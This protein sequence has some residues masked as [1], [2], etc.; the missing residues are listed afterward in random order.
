MPK[1]YWRRPNDGA[2]IPLLQ[3]AFIDNTD[4]KEQVL[5]KIVEVK[6]WDDF[7]QKRNEMI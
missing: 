4:V 3:D 7:K 6:V 2:V 5:H 1:E